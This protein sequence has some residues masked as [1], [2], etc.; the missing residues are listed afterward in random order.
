MTQAAIQADCSPS[1]TVSNLRRMAR[2]PMKPRTIRASDELWEG[3]LKTA[4][5]AGEYLPDRIREYLAW[6]QRLPGARQPS[7]P[8]APETKE[9]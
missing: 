4:D 1:A 5:D 3:A 2:K 8:P 9:G 7:R 6:Y